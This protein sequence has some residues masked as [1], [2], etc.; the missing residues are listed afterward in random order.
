MRID[1]IVNRQARMYQRD[2]TLLGRMQSAARGRCNFHVSASL[3]DLEGLCRDIASQGSDLVLFSGGDGSLMAGVSALEESLAKSDQALPAIAPVP[4]GTAGT[5]ARNWG[6]SGEPTRCLDRL[7]GRPRRLL[8]RPSLRIEAHAADG[9]PPWRRIGFIVGTGLVARFFQLYY[10]RGAP[11]YAGSA[12]LVSRIFFE[13]FVGGPVARRVLEPLPCQLEVD[14]QLLTP[15]AWS[16]V[17]ASVVRNL[18]IHML[19]THRAAEDPQRPHLVATPLPPRE[20]GPRAPLVL[21]GKPIG[22]RDNVDQLVDRFAICF[23]NSGPWVLDGELL[24]AQRIEVSAGPLLSV[25]QPI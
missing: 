10:E 11:G 20:L 13:S 15:P 5:V 21:S 19:V 6:L 16:L 22:G 9:E 12:K 4:G 25:A 24:R 3:Q 8:R 17:C 14:G 23:A 7:L 1:L 18:G 2:A